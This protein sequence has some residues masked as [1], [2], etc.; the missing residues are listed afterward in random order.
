MLRRPFDLTGADFPIV[1]RPLGEFAAVEPLLA[2][3]L[4]G[5]LYEVE[6]WIA[7][8]RPLQFPP[9]SDRKLQR[10]STA[11][12]IAVERR[13]HSLAALLLA[14]GYDPNGDYYEC[15]TPAVQAKD[16]EM[17][18]LLL[19]FGADPQCLDFCAVLET[20]DRALMDR[21][22]EA[23]IDPCRG[24]AVARALG[25]RG[26]P[27]LG[28]VR[29]YRDRFPGFQRQVDI[30]LRV[31]T[32][33]ENPRRIALMLWLGGNPHAEVP[34][35]A[36]EDDRGNTIGDT[37]F[38]SSLWA[39]KPEI[40]TQFLKGPIPKE[41]IEPLLFRVS[42]RAR[43]DLTR[44]LLTEGANPNA[45]GEEGYP[46]LHGFI[47]SL[48]WRHSRPT[49]EEGERGIEALE[50]MLKAGAKWALDERQLKGLRRDLADGESK[51]VIRL[52]D[53][54]HQYDA[55]TPEQLQ[56]LTRTPAVRRVLNG[57]SKPRRDPFSTYHSPLPSIAAPAVEQPRSGYWKRH[58][59]QR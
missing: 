31:A 29:Q 41:R 15:L 35:T 8:G 51:I 37:A 10:R 49:A 59:S 1:Y 45:M 32:E 53:L 12:Q 33:A 9:P 19:R 42:Y 21:F 23:G 40:L 25:Y 26:R 55:V 52:L 16:R 6:R 34:A 43:P 17:V 36:E 50:L 39:R 28:F 46:V 30:A 2:L 58:W 54:L 7:D 44:R 57:I 13:F 18:D 48:L 14:N 20:C 11:L 56:E 27:I 47:T 38:E 4:S 22:I 3:C 5:K 24:N